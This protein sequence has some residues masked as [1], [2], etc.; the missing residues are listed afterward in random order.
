MKRISILFIAL[1]AVGIT[2][3]QL[4]NMLID[5]QVPNIELSTL[6]GKEVKVLDAIGTGKITVINFWATW[7]AP[8]KMELANMADLYPDWKRDYNVQIIAISMDESKN[9]A[10]VKTYLDGRSWNYTIL[11]DGNHDLQRAM[12]IQ[13]PPY[14]LLLDKSGTIVHSHNGYKEGD[15][16]I[17]EDQIKALSKR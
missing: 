5:K 10:K 4:R 2:C 3:A 15:E 7:C 1:L 11:L 17:L 16:F 9:L 6:D 13:N 14:T 8:C 12:N